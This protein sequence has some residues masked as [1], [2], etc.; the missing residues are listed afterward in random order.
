MT[1]LRPSGEWVISLETKKLSYKKRYLIYISL[2][3]VILI[4]LIFVVNGSFFETYYTKGKLNLMKS[5]YADINQAVLDGEYDS[6]EFESEFNAL[7][8]KDNVSMVILDTDNSTLIGS[9]QDNEALSRRLLGYIFGRAEMVDTKTVEEAEKYSIYRGFEP[10]TQTEY[11]DMFGI[12]DNGYLFLIRS[13]IA[14]MQESVRISSRFFNIVIAVVCVALVV[15]LVVVSRAVALA[16]LKEKNE[17]LERDI[18][19]KEKI[20]E[21]RKEFLSNVSHELKTPIALIQGYAE[22]LKEAVNSDEESRDFYCDVIMDEASKMNGMVKKL[23]DLNHIEFGDIELNPVDFDIV[24]VISNYLSASDILIKQ[25]EV[26]LTFED[27]DPVY[28]CADEYYVEEVF[29]NYFSNALNHVDGEKKISIRVEKLD[30]FAKISVFNTGENIPEE[31]LPQIWDKFYNVDKARTREY[32]GSGVGLSIV[33]AIV[34]KMGGEYGAVNYNEGV[35]F[36]FTVR[37]SD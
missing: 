15:L 30:S 28:V 26:N 24:S 21:M 19:Q 10:Q 35:E 3:I 22:G 23:L 1:L 27:S 4:A 25:K 17:Q 18:A 37:L 12:L 32:G 8:E 9:T 31:S 34:E 13:S 6:E 11:L 33:K 29:N 2:G 16:E 20:D 5:A 7:C 14:G 36:Y